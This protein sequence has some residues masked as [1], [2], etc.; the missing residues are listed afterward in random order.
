MLRCTRAASVPERANVDLRTIPLP[1]PPPAAAT[2]GP[3]DNGALTPTVVDDR[4]PDPT[5]TPAPAPPSAANPVGEPRP[6]M[7]LRMTP[8]PSGAITRRTVI[9]PDDEE[10]GAVPDPNPDPDLDLKLDS[11]PPKVP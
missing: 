2:G 3:T 9:L 10:D 5:P 8:V 1:P 7:E 11:E 4:P 6:V